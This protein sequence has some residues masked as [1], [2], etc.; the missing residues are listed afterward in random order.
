[1][2]ILIER[3]DRQ[4]QVGKIKKQDRSGTDGSP[5]HQER[6]IQKQEIVKPKKGPDRLMI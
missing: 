6:N 5:I 3:I 1:M 2:G 4:S